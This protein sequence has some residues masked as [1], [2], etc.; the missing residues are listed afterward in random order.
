MQ[1]TLVICGLEH[2]G[3]TLISELFRQIPHI[4]S[5]FE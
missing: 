2:T 3:T 5:G 4:D 1:P